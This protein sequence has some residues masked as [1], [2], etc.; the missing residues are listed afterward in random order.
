M[1]ICVKILCVCVC[2]CVCVYKGVREGVGEEGEREWISRGKKIYGF[3]W[4]QALLKKKKKKVLFL[5]VYLWFGACW[6][7][8]EKLDSPSCLGWTRTFYGASG[9]STL[10]SAVATLV[11][12]EIQITEIYFFK[13][14]TSLKLLIKIKF[15]LATQ[16]TL[17]D[18]ALIVI[19]E[20]LW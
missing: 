13:R 9:I 15:S 11:P 3:M 8:E 2:V 6:L 17:T 14:Y 19:D 12:S 16:C 10:M 20:I 4:C 5:R 7:P 18:S 1:L